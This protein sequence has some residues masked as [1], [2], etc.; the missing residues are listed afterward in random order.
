MAKPL[1]LSELV[2]QVGDDVIVVQNLI[3]N[4]KNVRR[5]RRDVTVTF[6]TA[7]HLISL[8]AVVAPEEAEYV[9]LVIWLP[10]K[11]VEEVATLYG[12]AQ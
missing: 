4:I 3:E 2:Q 12:G 1:P 11:R 6:V 10:R 7:P 8:A 9:G 5:G